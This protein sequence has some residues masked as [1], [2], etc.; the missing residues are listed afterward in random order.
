MYPSN[1]TSNDGWWC[2]EWR[3]A[4]H[5]VYQ[6]GNLFLAAAFIIPDDYRHHAKLFR[7]LIDALLDFMGAFVHEG[8]HAAE[9]MTN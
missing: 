6:I 1:V 7:S 4:H 8:S 9:Y 5:F 2:R 3:V